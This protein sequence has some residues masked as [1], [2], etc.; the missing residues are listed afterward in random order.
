[1]TDHVR[2]GRRAA[3]TALAALA[4]VGATACSSK[5]DDDTAAGGV[6]DGTQSAD[7]TAAAD[8]LGEE[9]PATDSPITVGFVTD[10]DTIAPD[11]EVVDAFEAAAQYVN[12]HLGGINGHELA[13]QHCSTENTP[14]TATQCAVEFTEAGVAAVIFASSAQDGAIMDG[15]AD[16]GIPVFAYQAAAPQLI[17]STNGFVLANSISLI[18][19]PALYAQEQGYDQVA[20][21]IIDVPAATGPITQ[22]AEPIY[23]NA[24]I[25]LQIVPIAPSVADMTP[26]IQEAISAGADLFTVIGSDDFMIS[27]LNAIGQLGYEGDVMIGNVSDEVQAGITGGLGGF[28]GS[29]PQTSDPSDA[30]VQLHDA[31]FEAY[32]DV[33]EV[34]QYATTAFITVVGFARALDG[35]TE[36]IDAASVQEALASMPAPQPV[37]LGG[38]I[39]FQCGTAPVAYAPAFCGTD[40]LQFVYGEDGEPT[41]FDVVTVPAEIFALD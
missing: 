14:A 38:G 32:L 9:N 17:T 3:L 28:L 34:D 12:E 8:V 5:D 23:E 25:G 30:D 7:T 26:Q 10:G 31:W 36:A 21:I 39:T 19:A 18:A 2:R 27:A 22:I 4:L 15:L 24:G 16:T 6:T 11:D 41:D 40:A 37:P 1:M 35:A 20:S 29:A 33:D 13:L